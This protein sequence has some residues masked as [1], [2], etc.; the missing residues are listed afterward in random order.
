[1]SDENPINEAAKSG[2]LD[3]LIRLRETFEWNEKTFTIAA[4][5][6]H[7]NILRYLYENGCPSN[8]DAGA[9]ITV[10]GHLECLKYLY[11]KGYEFN[12]YHTRNVSSNGHLECL[13]FLYENG[14][15]ISAKS[16][17]RAVV[18]GKIE[19]LRFL[20]G[21]G[22]PIENFTV[23]SAARGGH[24]EILQYLILNNCPYDI[25]GILIGLSYQTSKI[26]FDTCYWLRS[27]LFP[28]VDSDKMPENLKTFCKEKLYQIELEK[29]TSKEQ[30]QNILSL[31]V[32]KYCLHN[33]I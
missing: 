1:M 7:L 17:M 15:P 31:D 24:F 27:F 6:G 16:A 9:W 23:S 14:C 5:F 29:E 13:R 18:E 11:E 22:C 32:V 30:L 8:W 26:N 10:N 25:K 4:R 19:C 33:Y 2:D 21:N 12:E 28:H 20:Y 3:L